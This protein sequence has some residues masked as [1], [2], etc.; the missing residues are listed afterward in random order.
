MKSIRLSKGLVLSLVTLVVLLTPSVGQVTAMSVSPSPPHATAQLIAPP[1]GTSLASGRGS[2]AVVYGRDRRGSVVEVPPENPSFSVKSGGPLGFSGADILQLGSSLGAAPQVA[3][4]AAGLG[5]T[6]E[7]DID[8]LSYGHDGEGDDTTV[9]PSCADFEDLALGARYHVGDVFVTGGTTVTGEAFVWSDGTPT[10][11]GYSEVQDQGLAGGSGQDMQVNNITLAFDFGGSISGLGLR[12]GEYGGNLNL[13]VNGDFRNFD[14]FADI[15]GA[16]I[17]GVQVSVVNGFGQDQGT[18]TLLGTI[19]SFS[20]GGQELWIDDVCPTVEGPPSEEQ[21]VLNFSV[22]PGATGQPG[23]AVDVE[24]SCQ[25]AE[26][27]GDEFAVTI[28]GQNEQ[29]FDE[30]GVPCSTNAGYP[31]GLTLEDDLDALNRQP[32]SFV[33]SNADGVPEAPVYFSLAPDSPSL[34]AL[35][36]TPAHILVSSGGGPPNV[37]ATPQELGLETGDDIDAFILWENGNGYFDP[38]GTT[39]PSGDLL[40]FSLAAGSPTLAALGR[41][42]ADLLVPNRLTSG[43]PPMLAFPAPLIGLV[44]D[45]DLN[46]LKG[47][48][49]FLGELPPFPPGEPPPVE[50]SPCVVNAVGGPEGWTSRAPLPIERE[51]GFAVIIGDRIYVGHGLSPFGDDNFH[52][53]YHIPTDTWYR[54]APAPIGRAEVT[55]VCAEENGEGR[56]FVFGGRQGSSVLN[57]V[58]VYDPVTDS[59]SARA[60]MPT[61]RAGMGAAWVPRLNAIFVIGGR[62]GSVPHSG[63]PLD[64]VEVYDL[65]TG[66]WT[67]AAP[68]PIPMMDVYS[69]V[70]DPVTHRIYVIGGFDGANVSDAV[71]IYDVATNTWHLG[72]RMPTPRSNLLAGFCNGLI[73]AIGGFAG[74]AG[75]PVG[76]PELD[77]NEAYHPMLDL[78]VSTFTPLPAPRSEFMTQGVSTGREIFAMG[79][80][81]HSNPGTPHDVY[82]CDNGATET[83]FVHIFTD[84]DQYSTSDTMTVGLALANRGSGQV[85]FLVLLLRTPWTTIPVATVPFFLPS[86]LAHSDPTLFSW[87]LPRLPAG[88][89]AWI[90]LLKP[91]RGDL[92]YGLAPWTFVGPVTGGGLEAAEKAIEEL[93]DSLDLNLGE[94]IGLQDSTDL[95]PAAAGPEAE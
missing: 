67:V 61:A 52:F 20:L 54:V 56:V 37:F 71:Q 43:D 68:M 48:A 32:P 2:G 72:A 36:V 38:A 31:L 21:E 7:D 76:G 10:T 39:N 49:T 44:T 41:S 64:V 95:A 75:V 90:A 86:S 9:S 82:T 69:T 13:T 35:G 28:P 14:N 89:Y 65:N 24:A 58:W 45:D 66:T 84:K 40:V 77:V 1:A 47:N 57:D 59:W 6:P 81:I 29:V 93:R 73:H 62:D 79:E 74:P 87:T 70:Y 60:P 51:G 63:A 42:P 22:R 80:G 50:P 83:L 85:V 88:N 33:D 55:G 30:N 19:T 25:P 16:T 53:M 26:V 3:I 8:A 78:W 4:P 17:G 23:T 91:L 18:L 92:A 5:L 94:E 15:D 46:A 11:D 12:F 27:A 34:T